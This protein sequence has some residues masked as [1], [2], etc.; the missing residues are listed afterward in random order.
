MTKIISNIYQF[1]LTL[2]GLTPLIWRRIQVPENYSFWDLHVAIQDSMGWFDS[3]LHQFEMNDPNTNEETTIITP[4]QEDSSDEDMVLEQQAKIKEYFSNT[5]T[6]AIYTYD[7]GDSWEHQ[8]VLE[9]IMT[10]SEGVR[11]PQCIAGKRSCPPEDCGG[12][13]GYQQL[14][15]VIK[16]PNH[17]DYEEQVE[18]LEDDFN[19]ETFNKDSIIFE[20]PKERLKGLF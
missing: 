16:D 20:D 9:K 10:I 15:E 11:Y 8:I 2:R 5:N 6:N 18:W 14:L 3:H 12:T 19:S 13:W 17:E 4:F 1:K 7:F